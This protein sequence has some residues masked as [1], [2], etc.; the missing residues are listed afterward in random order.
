ML[1]TLE[2]N[3]LYSIFFTT[4]FLTTLLNLAKSLGTGVNLP[5]SGLS[6]SV[7]RLAKIDSSAKLLTSI[8]DA[9]FIS[10]FVA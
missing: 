4:L 9:F 5:I 10:V 8:C 6:T 1:F 7:F 3:L 2:T